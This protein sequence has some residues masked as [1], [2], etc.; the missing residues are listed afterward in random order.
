MSHIDSDPD[1][2]DPELAELEM[3][4]NGTLDLI[5]S[6]RLD[7]AERICL[8]LKMRYPDQIDWIRHSA[9]LKEA[10]GQ[11]EQAIEHYQKCLTHID[12]YP[13]GFDSD[14]R[15][16]Y[17]NHARLRSMRPRSG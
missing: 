12:R 17:R 15:A 14:S 3:L 7:E 1:W 11:I 8:A 2:F 10:S 13:D 5:E 16:W 4:S 6:G 9:A